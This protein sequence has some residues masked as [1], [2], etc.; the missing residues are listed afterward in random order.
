MPNVL[1]KV[2]EKMDKRFLAVCVMTYEHPQTVVKILK[3]FYFLAEELGFD[4]Y[5]YDSSRDDETE[6]I[7]NDYQSKSKH[8]FYKRIPS[9]M[10]PDYKFLLPYD[11]ANL[12]YEYKYLWPVKDRIVPDVTLIANIYQRLLMGTDI[13]ALSYGYANDIFKEKAKQGS[14]NKEEF[15]RDYAWLT[16]DFY[17]IIYNYDTV[18]ADFCLEEITGRYFFDDENCKSKKCYF[19]HTATLFHYLAKLQNPRIEIIRMWNNKKNTIFSDPI[20]SGWKNSN[21]GI[22]IFG[23]YW[24]KINYALP[25]VYDR[26]KKPAI[27]KET[28]LAVLFGSVDGLIA[29]H[30]HEHDSLKY[31]K[32]MLPTWADYS[33]IPP[34]IA[35]DISQGDFTS[36][37]NDFIEKFNHFVNSGEMEEL[38][39]LCRING[40]IKILTPFCNDKGAAEI[41]DQAYEYFDKKL[42]GF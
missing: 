13:L 39:V 32:Q 4:I 23:L 9:D 20:E 30:F 33:D 38:A 26:Y 40:W 27:R 19:P 22:E 12:P 14:I 41:F 21:I 34:E 10:P 15:Y 36:A 8:V 16:T 37:Y 24:P 35:E 3:N 29:L 2:G 11:K 6:K 25:S 31:T 42:A 28:N 1:R 18:L 7:V 5:Y 17:T